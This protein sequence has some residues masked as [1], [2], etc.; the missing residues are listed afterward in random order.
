MRKIVIPSL[1]AVLLSAAPLAAADYLVY[2]GTYTRPG[3]NGS[4]GIY[5]YRFETPSGKLTPLGLAAE[6]SNPSFL[7]EHPNHKFVYAVGE[8]GRGTVTAFSVEPKT[9][10]LTMLNQVSSGG[11]GPCHLAIDHTG[12]WIAVANYNDGAFTMIPVDAD[13]KLGTPQ[14]EKHTGSS[15]NASRQSGPHAHDVVFTPDNRY[16]LLADL[17]LDKIFVYH[18]DPQKG[19]TPNDPPSGSVAPGAGVRHM[20][21]HPN[22]KIL[23]AIAEL[24]STITAF[25]FDQAKGTL[26]A[27]QTI[28]TLPDD[29]KGNNS[30]AE[31]QVNKAGTV[32]YGSNRGHD[33]IA[34]FNIDPRRFTLS[35]AGHVPTL[36]RTPRHFTLDPTGGY[37]FVANQDSSTIAMFKVHP[38]TGQLM[39]HGEIVKDAP[40]PVC[41]L[42]VPE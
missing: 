5:A 18:F 37:L 11:S 31:I 28:S 19:I 22:G 6:T 24:N 17:G 2:A 40:M 35:A 1:F 21:F 36:G 10:K 32:L 25:N 7:I 15:A 12:K 13:G 33:S 8:G 23:Y 29:F 41:V 39:P 34:L 42:F 3:P 27:F 38:T 20:A 9:G 14:T 16:L 26:M 30:T 4:K